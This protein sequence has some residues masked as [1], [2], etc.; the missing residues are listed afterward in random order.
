MKTLKVLILRR[1]RLTKDEEIALRARC[2]G[3]P[4]EFECIRIDP[5]NHLE[6]DELCRLHGVTAEEGIVILPMSQ[7]IPS[8]AMARGIRHVAFTS[9]G[10]MELDALPPPIFKPLE[11]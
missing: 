11:I 7:Q 8:T 3:E 5:A 6:H 4:V 2:N 1:D 10:A 9:A